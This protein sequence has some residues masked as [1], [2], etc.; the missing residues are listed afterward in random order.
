MKILPEVPSFVSWPYRTRT[1]WPLMEVVPALESVVE[2]VLVFPRNSSASWPVVKNE[3]SWLKSELLAEP[4]TQRSAKREAACA[5]LCLRQKAAPARKYKLPPTLTIWTV[6]PL[7]LTVPKPLPFLLAV[8]AS[9][10][11][12]PLSWTM[13]VTLKLWAPTTAEV[14]L[15]RICRGEALAIPFPEAP[16]SVA[17]STA[18]ASPP[19]AAPTA[20]NPE[21]FIRRASSCPG[22]RRPSRSVVVGASP[23]GP[24]PSSYVEG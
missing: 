12:C 21:R 9:A 13:P 20:A 11:V 22:Q 8:T 15:A 6:C 3:A 7:R 19:R 24:R 14:A 17:S 23:P 10:V 2:E 18:A 5:P 1:R 16:D 4:C